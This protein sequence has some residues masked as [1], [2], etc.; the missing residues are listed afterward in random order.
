MKRISI[1]LSVLFFCHIFTVAQSVSDWQKVKYISGDENIAV[2]TSEGEA[3]K[4]SEVG[5]DAK[6]RL[7]Y[8][9]FYKGVIGFNDTEPLITKDNR[10]YTDPFFNES[11][12]YES[13]ILDM[14]GADDTHKENRKHRA[15]CT[16]TVSMKLLKKYLSESGLMEST[17]PV[18]GEEGSPQ[19]PKIIVVPF[20]KTGENYLSILENDFDRR[21]A[22][23]NV[24]D[25]FRSRN[26][27][28]M[29][30]IADLRA[31]QRRAEFENNS[32]AADS[33]DKQLLMSSGADVYVEVDM[34]KDKNSQG[35]RVSLVMR[36]Y[37]TATGALLASKD[38]FTRRYPN[39]GSDLLAKYAVKDHLQPFLDDICSHWDGSG[40]GTKGS[41]ST[42]V[43]LQF[44]FGG[45]ATMSFN[46]RVGPK[47]YSLSNIIRQWVRKNCYKGQYHL[48]GIMAESI[49]F[50]SVTIPPTD[51][52]G[53]AM[54]AAQFA[55]LLQTSMQEETGLSFEPKIDG[56]NIIF[57]I[58]EEDN[59]NY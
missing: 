47:N 45:D 35:T 2:F 4:K 28:T 22:V 32:N 41:T 3:S 18:F 49:I 38:G 5:K 14:E 30:Y 16:I 13:Y 26:V 57:I 9:L 8:A 36:A 50:D 42:R 24:Q 31:I 48:K 21:V 10:L 43:V 44:A 11:Q 6:C 53:L 7:F 12:R 37:E 39:A 51:A 59:N 20:K 15:T 29:D 25:G 19:M 55:F 34:I 27:T 54:D 40:K 56:N 17:A 33:N 46:D 58:D 1:L 52:D 23:S